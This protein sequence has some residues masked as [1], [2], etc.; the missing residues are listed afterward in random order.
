VPALLTAAERAVEERRRAVRLLLRSPLIRPH[1]PDPVGF[2]LVR[3]HAEPVGRWFR[4]Q[5]GWTLVVDPR[6]RF[7]RLHK[8][9]A[10]GDPTH[11][12]V[13]PGRE[14]PFD[15]RRYVL[16][17]VTSAELDASGAQQT[18]LS[19]LGDGVRARTQVE[20]GIDTFEP[21]IYGE[22]KAFIDVLAMLEGLGVLTIREGDAER[23]FSGI[24]EDDAFYDIDRGLLGHLVAVGGTKIPS[25]AAGPDELLDEPY[26]PTDR[27]RQARD[28]HAVMRRLI[29][30]PA[31]YEEDLAEGERMHLL[32]RRGLDDELMEWTGMII[33]RRAEG[34]AAIDEAD[35]LVDRVHFPGEGVRPHAALL[36]AEWLAEGLRSAANPILIVPIAEI[37]A[38]VAGLIEEHRA[39][40]PPTYLARPNAAEVVTAD[41]LAILAAYRLVRFAPSGVRPM[42]A[43]ARF[44]PAAVPERAV[45]GEQLGL[46]FAP[47]EAT[48]S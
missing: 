13:A 4:E 44:R 11:P 21:T 45:F 37:E 7:A 46:T 36:L 14:R 22:R 25:Q 17:C 33:E 29:D 10:T 48:P 16:F 8:R 39:H 3:R 5:L 43:I 35:E 23:Y 12:A 42:P 6:G 20:A 15:V 38:R 30:D 19:R 28:R 41:A 18:I 27:G 47:P 40:W 9:V 26:P 2:T 31:V 24:A 32:Q 34:I 1:D